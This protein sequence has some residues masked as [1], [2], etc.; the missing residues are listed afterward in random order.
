MNPSSLP[1]L[2]GLAGPD[3]VGKGT[4]A[5]HFDTAAASVGLRVEVHS[6]AAPLYDCVSRICGVPVA[7]IKRR[8]AEV[9]TVDTAPLPF[10]VG[11]SFRWFLRILGTEAGRGVIHDQVWVQAAVRDAQ[12]AKRD[13][14]A[15]IVVFDDLRFPNEAAACNIVVE[16]DRTGVSYSTEHASAAGL[17]P[18]V[19]RH[20]LNIDPGPTNAALR[21]LSLVD[22]YWA[23][24]TPVSS[25]DGPAG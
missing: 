19:Q 7:E 25:V 24:N 13:R 3:C 1:L 8:K 21:V 20:R 11:K 10:L 9:F 15:D 12:I 2:I 23:A 5:S 16:L 22:A 4:T 17:P 6:F 14:Q 18:E